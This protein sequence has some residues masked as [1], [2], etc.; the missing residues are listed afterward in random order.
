[1]QGEW[2]LARLCGRRFQFPSRCSTAER[3]R[4]S[5]ESI[6]KRVVKESKRA[7]VRHTTVD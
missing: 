6:E 7:S 3:K 1:M 5:F 2:L 4:E